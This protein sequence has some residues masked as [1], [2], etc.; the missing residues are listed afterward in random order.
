[1]FNFLVKKGKFSFKGGI[2]PKENKFFTEN[3]PIEILPL[4]KIVYLPLSQHTG[5]EAKPIKK[6]GDYVKTGELIGSADGKISCNIHSSVSGIIKDLKELSHPL[7]G[8]RVLTYIIESDGKDLWEENISKE[9]KEK[10][11][12]SEEI[13]EKVFSC[14]IV[15]LG[16]A[17]FP[18]HVKLQPPKEIDTLIINGCECEPYLTNDYRLMVEKPKEIIKGA[19]LLR[20]ALAKNGK[21]IRLIFGIEDNKKKAIEIFNAYKKEYNFEVFAL[22]TKYPQGA[23]K[24]LIYALLKREVPSGGLPFDVGC[25]VHNVGTAYATYEACYFNKPLFERVVTVSGNGIKEKKN[26]LVRIGTPLK[27][28]VDYCGGFNGE[29]K[30]IIFGGPLMGIAVYSLEMPILKGTTGVLFFNEKEVTIEKERDCIRCG[31]CVASCP[32]GLL[33]AELHKFIKKKEFSKAKEYSVLD[34]IECGSCA[35]VCPS[36]IKL[37]Q[38]FKYAKQEIIKMEKK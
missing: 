30:K 18:T 26:L 27:D 1:M 36:K 10:D 33:P 8:K 22:K 11:F 9:E 37:V 23:E 2:F 34:C 38:Y 12:N 3:C 14:G 29:I 5:K 21:N 35:Y 17:T 32:M 7:L 25:L 6:V 31:R 28:I 19:L 16:G 4:P 24:Q 13:I 15:G 20:K